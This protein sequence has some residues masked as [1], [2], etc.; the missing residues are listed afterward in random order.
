MA[1]LPDLPSPSNTE[2]DSDEEQN[3]LQKRLWNLRVDFSMEETVYKAKM[4]EI[5]SKNK[6]TRLDKKAK[7]LIGKISKLDP[8]SQMKDRDIVMLIAVPSSSFR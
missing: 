2:V 6:M 3:S 5:R 1:E 4:K 8:P 7:D